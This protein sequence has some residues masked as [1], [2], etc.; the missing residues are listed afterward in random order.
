MLHALFVIAGRFALA[1]DRWRTRVARRR[2]LHAEIDALHETLARLR[3]HANVETPE[4]FSPSVHAPAA[5]H[6]PMIRKG[7][8]NRVFRGRPAQPMLCA[9]VQSDGEER[10]AV[11]A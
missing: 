8:V 11:S 3:A 1:H 5:S 9:E 7:S 6:R 4:T 2:P 10:S